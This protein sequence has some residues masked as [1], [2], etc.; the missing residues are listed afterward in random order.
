MLPVVTS[1]I[2]PVQN[3]I[4]ELKGLVP[5]KCGGSPVPS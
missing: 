3:F 2:V 1:E 5:T 4:E